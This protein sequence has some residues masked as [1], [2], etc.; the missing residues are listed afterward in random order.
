M[1]WS[2][3]FLGNGICD[4]EC[5][6]RECNYDTSPDELEGRDIN[7]QDFEQYSDWEFDWLATW[8][9]GW[10]GD[11]VC[12]TECNIPECGFDLGDCGFICNF[13]CLTS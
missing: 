5:M 7:N 3:N 1:E 11:E 12:D 9:P 13:D 2:T 6:T 10:A 4:L 8:P